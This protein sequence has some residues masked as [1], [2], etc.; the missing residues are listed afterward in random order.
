M[1]GLSFEEIRDVTGAPVTGLK[2]R[3]IRARARLRK[4]LEKSV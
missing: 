4:L 2:I 1:M 3:A